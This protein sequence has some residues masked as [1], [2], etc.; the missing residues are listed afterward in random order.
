MD[1]D[2]AL[3][4]KNVSSSLTEPLPETEVYLR[5]LI[6]Y[7]ILDIASGLPRKRTSD[8]EFRKP[9]ANSRELYG[10]AIAF[11]HETIEKIHTFNR[12]SLDPIAAKL[13]FAVGLAYE[14]NGNLYDLRP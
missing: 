13:W 3:G 14:M 2:T 5:L 12:R 11:S 4:K 10:K 6:L 9:A 1:V 8:T 7:R